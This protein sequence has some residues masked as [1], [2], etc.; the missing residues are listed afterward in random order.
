MIDITKKFLILNNEIIYFDI[1][2]DFAIQKRMAFQETSSSYYELS[3]LQPG[4][5]TAELDI[6]PST[7]IN[8]LTTIKDNKIGAYLYNYPLIF[9][10]STILIKPS[11]RKL[12]SSK[13]HKNSDYVDI[14]IEHSKKYSPISKLEPLINLICDETNKK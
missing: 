10:S 6:P 4:I 11:G 5:L 7:L 14:I 3:K 9:N 2:L 12:N 8:F 13:L 1:I